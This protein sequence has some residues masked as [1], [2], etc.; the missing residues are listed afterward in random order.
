MEND[1]QEDLVPPWVVESIE[2]E[3]LPRIKLGNIEIKQDDIMPTYH[4]SSLKFNTKPDR[5]LNTMVVLV[6]IPQIILKIT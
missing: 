6:N 2:E 3:D 4:E 1:F 5:L